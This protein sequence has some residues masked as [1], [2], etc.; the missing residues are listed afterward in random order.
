MLNDDD[1]TI[2]SAV[3]VVQSLAFTQHDD[4]ISITGQ[5]AVLLEER[6]LIWICLPSMLCGFQNTL[7]HLIDGSDNENNTLIV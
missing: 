5:L 6:L 1:D 2:I 3:C 4:F 7:F